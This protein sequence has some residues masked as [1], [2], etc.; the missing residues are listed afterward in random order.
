IDTL[1]NLATRV[2]VRREFD[3][4]LVHLEDVI[5]RVLRNLAT[6][7]EARRVSI[8]YEPDRNL[9]A[10]LA[11]AQQLQE[12]IQNLVHN[13]I[14]FNKIGGRICLETGIAGSDL[15]LQITD[16]GVGIPEERV[17]TIWNGLAAIHTNGGPKRPSMGLALTHFIVAAHGG[18]V[19]AT[20]QYGQ[21]STFTIFL[22]LVFD[23]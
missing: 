22:P 9:P 5:Q 13:A 21:G 7:A 20:S 14:K 3:F 1:I 10:V 18:R 23:E 16:S 8:E 4:N 12:A 19:Q 17:E 2:Q 15:Y 6:M 11:D